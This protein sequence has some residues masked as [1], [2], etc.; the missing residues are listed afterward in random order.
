MSETTVNE[1]T[2]PDASCCGPAVPKDTG[3]VI[4]A[5]HTVRKQMAWTALGVAFVVLL[6]ADTE[7]VPTTL[8]FVAQNLL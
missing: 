2:T 8:G 7:Q 3:I 1:T 4:R 6:F 5:L